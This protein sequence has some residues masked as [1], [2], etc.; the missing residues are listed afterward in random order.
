MPSGPR[1][2][3]ETRR[4]AGLRRDCAVGLNVLFLGLGYTAEALIRRA[5]SIEP[6]GTARSEA[7][8]AELRAGGVEAFVFD[9]TRADPG[10]EDAVRR[11]EA[12]VVS[13]PPGAPGPLDPLRPAIAAAQNLSRIVYFSTVGVYGEHRGGWVDET[14][15]TRTRAPRSLARPRRRGA[16]GPRRAGRPARPSTSC[17]CRASTDRDATRSNG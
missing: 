3:S 6:S 15:E 10:L 11:A 16:A 8:V 5:P 9:G 7:R 13:I 4:T 14:A 12:I 2:A 17:A 1:G